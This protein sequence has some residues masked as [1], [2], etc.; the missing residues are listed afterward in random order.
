MNPTGSR[1]PWLLAALLAACLGLGACAT[2]GG[3]T[4]VTGSAPSTA[5]AAAAPV[6]NPADPWERWNRRVYAFNDAIDSAVIRPL[7]EGYVKVVP[8]PVRQAVGNFGN[9]FGDAW[10]AVN[11]LL[12]G[13]FEGAMNSVMRVATNSVFGLGG[14]IDIASE[15]GIERQ[16]EDLGQTL[17][18]WG[19]P[20]GPYVVLPLLGSSS[21]RD[22]ATLI[23]DL[24][25]SPTLLTD[26]HAAQGGLLS[27][28][29]ID[30]RA[31]L[32]PAT[33]MLDSIALDKYTFVRDAYLQRRLNDVYDGNPPQPKDEDD[34]AEA[35]PATGAPSA[36]PERARVPGQPS[37]PAAR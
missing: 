23:P 37:R 21:V 28:Y 18:R 27:L 9:N 12:Q 32:L 7:A 31:N 30:T 4:G 16:R 10:S 20:A 34:E 22:S 11:H 6:L 36:A 14:L 2:T 1:P 3:A 25:V 35:A 29:L 19:V 8:S 24:Y 15:A 17:G 33:R 5:A 26:N 13:K